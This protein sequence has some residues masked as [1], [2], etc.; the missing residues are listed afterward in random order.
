[1][2]TVQP[3]PAQLSAPVAPIHPTNREFHGRTF[4]DDYEWMRNKESQETLDYLEAENAYTKQQTAKNEWLQDSIFQ[5]IKSR[6]KE[7]DMSIPQRAGDFWYYGRTIEGK[8]YGVSCRVPVAEGEDPWT[9]PVV[10]EDGSGLPNEQIILD[11]NELAEGHEFF[12]LGASSVTVSGRYLAYSVDTEGDERFTMHV[13]D[14]E[15]G[16]LLDDRLD[17][18]FYGATWAGE[19]YLFYQRVDEAWRPDSVWRHKIGT[20]AAD[21]VLVYREDDERFNV[22]VGAERSERFLM[23]ESGSKITTETRV[24]DITN[25]EGEFEVLWP[26]EQGVEYGVDYALVAG[27]EHWVVTH[28]AL[29]PNFSVGHC[30]IGNLPPLRELT[31]LVPHDD[32]VRIEGIDTYRDFMAMGYRRGGIGQVAFMQFTEAG[33]TQFEE[34]SFEEEVYTVGVGGNPEWDAPVVR[35]SYV[36]FTQ[37]AKLFNYTVATG[38]RT[39]LKEQEVLGGYDPQEYKA[40]RMWATAEDGVQIPVSVVHRADLVVDKPNPTLLYAYGSYEHSIDPGFSI[41]RLSL[42]DR[43]MI[44]AVAHVR[45]GGEMGRT[46]YEDGKLLRKKNTFTDFIAAADMLIDE[47]LTTPAQLVAEG[48]SAGGMLMGAIA[49]MA[50]E[51]F[52]GIQAIVPFVDPLT[53][54]LMPELPLTVTEW[55]EWGDPYHDPEVYDYMASYAPYENIEPKR[56][57]NILAVTSLNDTRVLY[58]EPA[59]WIAKLRKM[60]TGGEFLLKCEMSAGHGGVSGRYDRWKQTAFEYAWTLATAGAVK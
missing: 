43:G 3:D 14:L 59:K 16:E 30:E 41:A 50:P 35:L 37:P 53:S 10:P 22:G 27:R 28:N 25:P 39:L 32:K 49:N 1:M 34:L 36:S 29:G 24:L 2:N 7:T 18:V 58:V 6:T 56:Y 44:F 38:E 55:D 12:S 57:P 33:F 20:P 60:A 19:D 8:S 11:L 47:G 21:D 17:D 45:G 48:G 13:K 5:E 26:R 31:E 46:W 4:V 54:I 40:Y 42:M 9:P 51:K 23:I 15:T 52:A